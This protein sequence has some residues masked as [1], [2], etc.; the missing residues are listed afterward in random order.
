MREEYVPEEGCAIELRWKR[1]QGVYKKQE[2]SVR[3]I[4]MQERQRMSVLQ[5]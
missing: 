5:R 3:E 2:I 4:C 1:N